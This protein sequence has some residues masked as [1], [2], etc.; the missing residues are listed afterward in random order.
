MF[1]EKLEKYLKRSSFFTEFTKI[2]S[3]N[4]PLIFNLN[5]SAKA[6]LAAFVFTVYKKNVLFVSSDD[7]I[8]EEV[9]DDFELLLG[10]DKAFFLPDY[11]I[12][13]YENRSPH[14]SIRAQRIDTLVNATS[15]NSK[16][17]YSLSIGSLIRNIVP[18]EIFKENIIN[19]AVDKDY[20]PDL[21]ISNLVG[22]GY[23]TQ[24][25]ITHV[26]QIAH[27]G[28][29]VDI[30]SPNYSY[31]I[32][33]EF[34]GDTI[35]SIRFFSVSSQISTNHSL[36]E[37]KIIPAREFSIHNIKTQSEKLWEKIHQ[38][39][40]YEGIEEDVSLLLENARQLTHSFPGNTN[41]N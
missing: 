3:E 14:Y 9:I 38:S 41:K 2:L 5:I 40:F 35:D 30:F 20:P 27:R 36:E 26:G 39:G 4:T 34:F 6:L 31:P 23:D 17:V 11:E 13:P 25:Q 12:L 29:I 33:I 21:L 8:A 22:M 24:Y 1:Y 18:A 37:C 15:N 32:R 19:L 28:G 7:K 10:R 16:A